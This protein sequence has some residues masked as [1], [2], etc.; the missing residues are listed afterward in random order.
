MKAYKIVEIEHGVMKTLFHGL[1]GSRILPKNIWLKAD[2][3]IVS[4]GGS[5]EYISGWHVLK[6]YSEC[7]EYLK[8]FKTRLDLLNI[9]ECE[10]KD[11]RPKSHSNSPVLLADYIIFK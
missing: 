1:N 10:V 2:K 11:I 5:T 6:Y 7:E 9:V 3:K 8:R 4:D